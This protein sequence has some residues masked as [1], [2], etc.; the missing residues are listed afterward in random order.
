MTDHIPLT[1]SLEGE[2]A[3]LINSI[4]NMKQL[5]ALKQKK[6]VTDSDIPL[7]GLFYLLPKIHIDQTSWTVSGEV[8]RGR[9][10]VSDCGSNAYHTAQYLSD[11]LNLTTGQ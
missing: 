9:P 3:K 11:F 7:S 5:I 10:V 4:L 2:M 1:H 6:Y 8:P